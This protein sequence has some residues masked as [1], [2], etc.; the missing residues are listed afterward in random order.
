MAG[1]K[2]A[3]ASAPDPDKLVVAQS[4]RAL[5]CAPNR[6]K[7]QT[8]HLPKRRRPQGR[9]RL[10]H[11]MPQRRSQTVPVDQ[12]GRRY[13]RV[14]RTLLPLQCPCN[15]RYDVANFWFRTLAQL[16]PILPMLPILPILRS[17]GS[18]SS[19]ILCTGD[20]N[21]KYDCAMSSA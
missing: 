2:A 16:A 17:E 15:D 8:R 4:G 9:H 13:P 12:V 6:Q 10:L 21:V 1:Q 11:R 14:R 5:L 7:N 19:P 20:P 18:M 3:L